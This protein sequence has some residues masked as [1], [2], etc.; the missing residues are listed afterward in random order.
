MNVKQAYKIANDVFSE[1]L[2]RSVQLQE[3]LSDVVDIGKEINSATN[4]SDLYDHYC[5]AAINR[6]GKDVFVDRVYKGRTPS[7]MKDAWEFGSILCKTDAEVGDFQ[8]SEAWQLNDGQVYEQDMYISPKVS[9]K[10]WNTREA[11]ELRMSRAEEQIKESLTSA[12]MLIAFFGMIETKIRNKNAKTAEEFGKRAINNMIG[13]TVHDNN[14]VRYVKLLTLYNAGPNSGGTPLTFP[15]CLHD[16]GFL[17]YAAYYMKL[18]QTRLRD[19]SVLFN[20]G[21]KERFTPGEKLHTILWEQFKSAAEVYLYDA[22]GQFL[23]D[24][25]KLPSAEVVS[26]WQS[27]GTS[28]AESA[29]SAID[30][31]TASGDAVNVA[32]IL[33]VMFDDEALGICNEKFTVRTH[34]NES[35]EFINFWY[36]T[37]FGLWNDTNE[38]FVVFAAV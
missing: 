5:K 16:A 9:Q 4:S 30:I 37:F 31:V 27:P 2:G 29:T 20:I 24:D 1:V 34:R 7:I 15:E 35:G 10:M 18:Y 6:I 22:Q 26:Y 13:E 25:I 38:N 8:P 3:D 36:K 14:G 21:G 32:G 28:Y 11:Y 19:M 17:R 33:G 23:T 12:T